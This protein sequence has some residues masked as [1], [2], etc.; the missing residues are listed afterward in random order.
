MKDRII[1]DIKKR[2]SEEVET[3]LEE[4]FDAGYEAAL[5]EHKVIPNT[6]EAPGA[7][8]SGI[9]YFSGLG[10]FIQTTQWK[11]SKC[12]LA[13]MAASI[14]AGL[15]LEKSNQ[16]VTYQDVREKAVDYAKEICDLISKEQE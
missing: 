10:D 1:E 5:N 2:W 7:G 4:A 6:F 12:L 15:V 14:F 16:L 8:G 3:L 11:P 9:K 13:Q